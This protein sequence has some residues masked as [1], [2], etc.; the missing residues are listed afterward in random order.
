VR[1]ALVL[2]AVLSL[3]PARARAAAA[4]PASGWTAAPSLAAGGDL[5]SSS[6]AVSELEVRLGRELGAARPELG[7]VLGLSPGTYAALR[8]GA[9]VDL[10]GAPFYARGALDYAHAGGD[11]R[12]RWFLI[13]AGAELRLTS[14]LSGFVEVDAGIPLDRHFGLGL[15]A[16]AGFAFRP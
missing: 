9:Q 12:W 11:W 13:G 10:P 15:L 1:S 6:D 3:A 4:A 16:R 5:G 7:L 14:V 2:L 8:P